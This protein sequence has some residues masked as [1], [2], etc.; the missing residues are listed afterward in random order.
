ML[1]QPDIEIVPAFM[2]LPQN[3][4]VRIVPTISDIARQDWNACFPG[5]VESYDYLLAVERAQLVGFDWRYV[6]V[7]HRGRVLAAA[8]AFLCDYGLETTLERGRLTQFVERIRAVFPRFLK[9]RL[10]CI[11]SPCT[12][13]GQI[14]IRPDVPEDWRKALLVELLRSF[15]AEAEREGYS[16]FALKDIP[17]PMAAPLSKALEMEQ[18]VSMEGMATAWLDIDFKTV[19]AYLERMS[20]GTRKDMRRKLRSASTVQIER[21]TELGDLLPRFMEIYASTRER[22]EWQFEELTAAYFEGILSR[23]PG[24]SFCTVYSVDGEVLAFNLVLRDGLRLIDKFFCMDADAGRAY[25][26][27]YLS[28][29]ENVRYCLEHG[30]RRYQSGQAY[31]ENKI[32]LGSSLTQNSMFFRHRNPVIQA[33]LMKMAAFFAIPQAGKQDP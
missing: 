13:T 9:L 2:P 10:A 4:Q 32:R 23:L 28:W 26:L 5:E 25:N 20:A 29:F 22:S 8:P 14:G 7:C 11:G 6:T 1:M 33:C 16:L 18:F 24:N 27:Y 30:Y 12:E 15:Q 21:V 17:Q 31:Y 19:D 3:F